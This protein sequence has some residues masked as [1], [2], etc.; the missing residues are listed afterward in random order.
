MKPIETTQEKLARVAGELGMAMR[1]QATGRWNTVRTASRDLGN[2]HV[3]RFRTGGGDP[4]RFLV[5]SHRA[6]TAGESPTASLLEQLQQARWLDR[7]QAGPETSFRLTSS[8][9][10]RARSAD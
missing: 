8:G 5:V 10:L 3:W 6:M 4:D 2:R 1:T 7:L 9:R